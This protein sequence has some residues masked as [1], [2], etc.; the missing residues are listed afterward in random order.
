MDLGLL[1]LR[2]G[3]GSIMFGHGAQKVMGWFGGGGP[4]MFLGWMASMGVPAPIAWLA[5]L[6]EF[7]GGIAVILGLFSRTAALGFAGNMLVA[8]AMVHWKNGFFGGEGGSGWEWSGML[9]C[10]ALT[11]VLAGPG[12]IAV[13]DEVRRT[14]SPRSA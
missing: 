5:M 8:T 14:R 2:L 4:K 1:V 7:V 3:L 10:A 9:L 11:I 13:F 12:R 6:V